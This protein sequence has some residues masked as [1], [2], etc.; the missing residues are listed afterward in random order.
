MRVFLDTNVLL[1][2]LL[3]EGGL[4]DR[5]MQ[6]VIEEYTM[7][8]GEYVLEET[9]EKLLG[10]FKLDREDAETYDT[11]LRENEVVPRPAQPH[12][13]PEDDPDDQWVL[14]TAIEGKSDVLVTGDKDLLRVADQVTEVAI[15]SP[16]AFVDTY[17]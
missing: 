3:W 13:L 15:L 16:R 11:E 9:K 2:A 14:A 17:L 8:V 5:L 6:A 1:S 10:K 4:C 7:V 12:R